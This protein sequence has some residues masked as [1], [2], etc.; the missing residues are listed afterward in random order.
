MNRSRPL[1]ALAPLA[2]LIACLSAEGCTTTA[3]TEPAPPPPAGSSCAVDGTVQC[4]DGTGYSCTGDAPDDSDS[5][6]LCS[7]AEGGQR[8]GRDLLLPPHLFRYD[9]RRR[10]HREL[11][12]RRLRL[13]VRKRQRVANHRVPG[14]HLQPRNAGQRW[15]R[16]VLLHGLSTSLATVASPPGQTATPESVTP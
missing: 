1:H 2:L 14:A 15:L 10:L 3:T 4:P 12:R 8:R 6:L 7:D 9:L 16:D 11:P 13:L 5:A